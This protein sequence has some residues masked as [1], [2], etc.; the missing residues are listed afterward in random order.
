MLQG[1]SFFGLPAWH[2]HQGE[3]RCLVL[4]SDKPVDGDIMIEA[5]MEN[6]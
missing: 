4:V 2:F 6:A 1:R 3:L 5:A